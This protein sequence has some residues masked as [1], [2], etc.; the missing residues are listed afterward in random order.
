LSQINAYVKRLA[1]IM[2]QL[3]VKKSVPTANERLDLLVSEIGARIS[4]QK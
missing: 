4:E 3:N 2:N 1:D